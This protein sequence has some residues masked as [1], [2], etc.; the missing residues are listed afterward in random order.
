MVGKRKEETVT[1]KADPG[2][3][4]ELKKL[5]NKSE[6]IRKA[7]LQAIG[8]EC[9]LCS[10]TGTLTPNQLKHWKEFKDHHH[11]IKCVT[12]NEVHLTCDVYNEARH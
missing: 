10:G 12:C 8:N 7:L 2:L 4:A 9:P 6:F 1:F 5:P 11:A 3:A